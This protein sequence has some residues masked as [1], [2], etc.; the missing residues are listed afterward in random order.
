[1]NIKKFDLSIIE[2]FN[3]IAEPLA[4]VGLFILFFWF[5]L[6]KILKIGPADD[7]VREYFMALGSPLVSFSTFLL[8]VGLFECL[9]GV[10][11]LIKGLERVVLPLLFLH[12]VNTFMPLLIMPEATWQGF[13]VPTLKGQYIIKNI[14]IVAV[15][16]ALG[17]RLHP[18]T[19]R[20]TK[21]VKSKKKS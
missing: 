6:L 11:F 19:K 16:I 9:I 8:L 10:L 13:L 3:K 1:M 4:R 20:Q 15:V 18:F 5:G 7:F 12:M 2:F 21:K 17:A 14:I